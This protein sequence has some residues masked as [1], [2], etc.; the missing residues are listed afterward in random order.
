M[1]CKMVLDTPMGEMLAV[2]DGNALHRLL[3]I[4]DDIDSKAYVDI[5]LGENSIIALLKEELGSYF[6]GN[7]KKFTT[8][9]N[10]SGTE[11]QKLVWKTLLSVK[12]GSTISYKEQA[13]L[14]GMPLSFRAVANGNS[15]NPIAIII[16][17]HRIV[18]SNGDVCGYRGGISKKILLIKHEKEFMC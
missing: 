18:R 6:S 15:R 17:C 11:F 5:P 13:I 3:F 10:P 1:L 7:I 2:A 14:M 8:P 16:P 12:Y 4:G 9:I